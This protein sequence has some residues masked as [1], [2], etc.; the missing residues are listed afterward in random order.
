MNL[1]AIS[2]LISNKFDICTVS[3]C[4]ARCTN[5]TPQMVKEPLARKVA[6]GLGNMNVYSLVYDAVFISAVVFVLRRFHI[7]VSI[8]TILILLKIAD[9]NSV[10]NQMKEQVVK[11]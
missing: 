11:A 8:A 2:N 5:S 6:A 7:L 10:F 4:Y 1:N 3:T 9:N